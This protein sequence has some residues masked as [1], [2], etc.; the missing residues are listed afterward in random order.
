[1]ARL[2]YRYK[3]TCKCSCEVLNRAECIIVMGLMTVNATETQ[4]TSRELG[5]LCVV[6]LDVRMMIVIVLIAALNIDFHNT[7][8]EGDGGQKPIAMIMIY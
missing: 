1:M 8:V 3:S 5:C 6:A 4:G 7:G 2:V